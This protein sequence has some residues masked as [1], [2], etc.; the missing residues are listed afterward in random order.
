MPDLNPL[1]TLDIVLAEGSV[2]GQRGGFG[3]APRR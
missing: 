1:V 3:S 2:T